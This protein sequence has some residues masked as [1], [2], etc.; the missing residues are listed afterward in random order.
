ME[1]FF[2]FSRLLDL[3]R[4]KSS[5]LINYTRKDNDIFKK[6]KTTMFF[7]FNKKEITNCLAVLFDKKMYHI[8]SSGMSGSEVSNGMLHLSREQYFPVV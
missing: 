5:E 7:N 6:K 3:S 8:Q 2:V 4:S 1:V